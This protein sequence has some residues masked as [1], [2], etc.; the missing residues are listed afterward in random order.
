MLTLFANRDETVVAQ[1]LQVLRDGRL[2]DAELVDQI[3][4]ADL[5]VGGHPEVR[6]LEKSLQQLTASAV[7][8]H[9]EDVGHD[10]RVV[11]RAGEYHGDRGCEG[12][13]HG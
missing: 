1:H 6:A 2:A 12:L 5:A 4:H 10:L 3:A 8:E 13:R 7:C 11:R 9:V